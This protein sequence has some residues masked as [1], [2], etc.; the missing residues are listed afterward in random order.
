MTPRK[1]KCYRCRWR[2]MEVEELTAPNPFDEEDIL[3]GCPLCKRVDTMVWA[4]DEHD[5]WSEV[6]CG[7]P[8]PNGYR[9]TCGHHAPKETK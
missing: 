3:V 1:I 9:S 5:C 2:G 8:T 6:T 4:C 7:T